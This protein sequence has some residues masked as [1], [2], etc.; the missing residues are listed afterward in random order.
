MIEV[1]KVFDVSVGKKR[2]INHF[3]K[4]GTILVLFVAKFVSLRY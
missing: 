2:N 3:C 4:K 1:F